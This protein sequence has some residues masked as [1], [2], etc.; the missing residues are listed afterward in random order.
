MYAVKPQYFDLSVNDLAAARR[1][2]AAVF[3]WEFERG[4][5]PFEYYRIKAGPGA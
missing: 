3:G 2:F 4:S 1:F 5:M